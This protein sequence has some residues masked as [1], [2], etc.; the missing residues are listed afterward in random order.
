MKLGYQMA[1]LVDK[2]LKEQGYDRN[3]NELDKMFNFFSEEELSM[4][5]ELELTEMYDVSGI[6][7][8]TNLK[9]LYIGSIDFSK[10]TT[11][12]SIKYNPYINKIFDFGFLRGLKT[13][14]E[15]QI[16]NDV[17]I[18]SLDVSN[19]ENLQT[20]VLI[21][22]P[23]LSKLKG[24]ED[25]KQLKNVVIY[26]NSITSD[27][28]IQRYIENTLATQTNILDISMYMSA[29]KG[30]RGLAKLISDAVLL[31]K[32]KLKFGEY[33][34][35]LNLSVVK[36]ENL[37]DMYTKLDIFFKRNDL[38]N[39]SEI[40]KIAF[41]YNYVVR[42]V[43]FAKEELERRNNEF[44]NIK[45]QNKE[46]PEYL[47][48]NFISLHNSYIAF[49]FKRA[50]CEGTVNLMSFMFHMLGIQS[51]NVH[52]IDKRFK[53]CFSP[54]HSLIRVMCDNDWYYCDPTYD[55]KEPNKY[56]M[57]KFEQLQD[58]HLFSD[59]EVMLNEEKKNEKY[60]GTDFNRPTK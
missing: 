9:K 4:I 3:I 49:H 10:A 7:H 5:T 40:D 14:E 45:R 58:T 23:K 42:N 19:L 2:T 22:N 46:V 13:L 59:F 18:K 8:L 31:G 33:I 25:L 50:N 1:L 16:E 36:P 55:L 44:L 54:N 56:F 47:V 41:V 27:F 51:T 11:G 39:A 52:C 35:F 12:K 21:H 48:K 34:G 60:N 6:E 53:N 57:K 30:D 32:T 38:Y 37:Y 28:D 29:V 24:L 26:G 20:L 17:N 43:R 15:L